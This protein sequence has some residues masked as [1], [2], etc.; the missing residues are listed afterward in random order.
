[1]RRF[2]GR[3]VAFG[4]VMAITAAGFSTVADESPWRFIVMG[5]TRGN[6]KGGS[7][8]NPNLTYVAQAIANENTTD[9]PVAFVVVPGDLV[10]GDYNYVAGESPSFAQM[11][12]N[13]LAAMAPV[14]NAGIQVYPIRGNHETKTDHF[15]PPLP[16]NDTAPW[17]QA[18][19]PY[20]YIPSN[21]PAGAERLTYS[22][23][24]K[25]ALL[26][27]IDNY[28]GVSNAQ[29]PVVP[30]DWVNQQLQSNTQ[31]HVFAFAHAPIVQVDIVS[32]LAQTSSLQMSYDFFDSLVNAGGKAYFCGHDH[33]YNRAVLELK[34]KRLYQMLV[35]C[36][37]ANPSPW[38]TG[39]Y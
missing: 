24:Y 7:G 9:N 26:I 28:A 19:S 39:V 37:G 38:H 12:Q 17:L 33:F 22:I 10:T 8:I 35:G 3:L 31:P 30:Q 13:W 18:F 14:Y 34:G 32:V 36:G 2:M 20:S 25:N 1:M 5:D 16:F 21:G 23:A 11:L 27:C 6:V 29:F 15:V 4:V